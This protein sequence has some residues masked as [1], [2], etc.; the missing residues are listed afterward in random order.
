MAEC[1]RNIDNAKILN[2]VSKFFLIKS[3]NKLKR[4]MISGECDIT[5]NQNDIFNHYAIIT[6]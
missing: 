3:S 2:T 4:H 5:W 1:T 6:D